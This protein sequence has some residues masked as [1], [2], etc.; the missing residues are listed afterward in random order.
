MTGEA[1]RGPE[2]AV[3]PQTP[4]LPIRLVRGS[5]S[6]DEISAVIAVVAVLAA[7]DSDEGPDESDSPGPGRGASSRS[8]WSAPARTVRGTHS[9]GPG[10]WRKSASPR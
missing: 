3:T 1:S 4:G 5:A 2:D 8:P 6:P 7:A 10:G 9:P